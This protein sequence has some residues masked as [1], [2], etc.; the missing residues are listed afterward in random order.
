V[1]T[2]KHTRRALGRMGPTVFVGPAAFPARFTGSLP[3]SYLST[4]N[5]CK[6]G[7][8]P[9]AEVAKCGGGVAPVWSR[10]FSLDLFSDPL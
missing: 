4:R 7:F 2:A 10:G 1:T 9:V 3:Q 8:A 6:Y 5:P